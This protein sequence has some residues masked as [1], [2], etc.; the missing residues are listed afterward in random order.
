MPPESSLSA[1]IQEA[2]TCSNHY[3][4]FLPTI[5][6]VS[7]HSVPCL[8]VS[9]AASASMLTTS[10]DA[11]ISAVQPSFI[12]AFT[13]APA[14]RYDRTSCAFL[15]LTASSSF[16]PLR[17]SWSSFLLRSEVNPFAKQ[18]SVC[19]QLDYG[20]RKRVLQGHAGDFVPPFSFPSIAF[21]FHIQ[22]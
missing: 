8:Y 3:N 13:S 2:C 21:L 20:D 12:T 10:S 1:S 19:L 17:L 9:A 7:C 14:S 4:M 5:I 6:S 18:L 22:A 11:L 15:L 16:L